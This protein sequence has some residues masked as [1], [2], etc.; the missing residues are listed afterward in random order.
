M[1]VGDAFGA[2]VTNRKGKFGCGVVDAVAHP[3]RIRP[4]RMRRVKKF[5]MN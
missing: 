5:F 1:R 3:A 4:A 2:T